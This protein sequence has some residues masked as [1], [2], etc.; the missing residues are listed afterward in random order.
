VF[1]RKYLEQEQD[2]G[3]V[4]LGREAPNIFSRTTHTIRARVGKYDYY[5][6]GGAFADRREELVDWGP[7]TETRSNEEGSWKIDAP[8]EW[9]RFFRFSNKEN[10]KALLKSGNAR[11]NE[12]NTLVPVE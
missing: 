11:L 10:V 2:L 5:F 8:P 3:K 12:L 6:V 1:T 4:Q 7:L 9:A